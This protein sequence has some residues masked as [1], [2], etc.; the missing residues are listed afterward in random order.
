MLYLTADSAMAISLKM[1]IS[2]SDFDENCAVGPLH[3]NPVDRVCPVAEIL[4]YS[5]YLCKKIS[6]TGK[7]LSHMKLQPGYRDENYF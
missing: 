4:P 6:A 2:L 3:M 1:T 7:K 5:Y